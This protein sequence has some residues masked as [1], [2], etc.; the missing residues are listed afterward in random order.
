M[1][2]PRILLGVAAILVVATAVAPRIP[3]EAAYMRFAD[4]RTFFGI[5][6]FMDVASNVAFLIAG[7]FGIVTVR[8]RVHGWSRWP[9]LV[10]FASIVGTAF[11]SAYYHLAPSLDRLVWDRV[12]MTLGFMGLLVA[13]VAERVHG[14]VARQLFVPLLLLGPASVLYWWWTEQTGAGDLRVY[15]L[16]QFGS[17]ILIALILLLYREGHSGTSWLGLGLALYAVAKA[18][19]VSDRWLLETTGIVSG[20]TMKHLLAA[21]AVGCAVVMLR[22]PVK[23][24]R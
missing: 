12:P 19:E 16:V 15:A 13:I 14:G 2:R 21:A 3:Q 20:H 1:S 6:N 7:I 23:R 18:F 17:L 4:A 5:P 11:G 9:W 24:K 22:V 8:S 10:V